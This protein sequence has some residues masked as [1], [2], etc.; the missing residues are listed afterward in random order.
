MGWSSATE[1]FDAVA[2]EVLVTGEAD[3]KAIIKAL[4]K[5]LRCGDW[6]S[7]TSSEYYEHP[8]VQE[9]IQERKDWLKSL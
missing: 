8:I 6:D 2:K 7:E 3:K 4:Y 9:V 5:E 1:I